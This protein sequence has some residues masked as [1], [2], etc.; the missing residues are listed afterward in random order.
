MGDYAQYLEE[1]DHLNKRYF[2]ENL[3]EKSAGFL[4]GQ[5]N[6]NKIQSDLISTIQSDDFAKWMAGY[7]AMPTIDDVEGADDILSRAEQSKTAITTL[8]NGDFY[9]SV[10]GQTQTVP[11]SQ[12]E[13][14]KKLNSGG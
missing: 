6:Q 7:F 2:G 8:D 12:S 9:L 3:D 4:I 1:N 10:D 14:I 5:S 11:S 13:L